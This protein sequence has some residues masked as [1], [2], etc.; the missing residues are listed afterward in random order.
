MVAA[1]NVIAIAVVAIAGIAAVAMHIAT[2]AV[3]IFFYI[4]VTWNWVCCGP[5]TAHCSPYIVTLRS[6]YM[7]WYNTTIA[8]WCGCGGDH[9]CNIA[10][11]WYDVVRNLKPCQC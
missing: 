9:N 11:T 10:A 2:V 4:F 5:N 8:I 7:N 6:I 1:A 3:W